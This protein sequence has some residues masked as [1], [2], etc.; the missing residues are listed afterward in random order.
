V[1]GKGLSLA[2]GYVQPVIKLGVSHVSALETDAT[3]L[4]VT[5]SK[6]DGTGRTI[7]IPLAIVALEYE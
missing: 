6:P 7:K 3:H 2:G 4:T 1:S 5:E